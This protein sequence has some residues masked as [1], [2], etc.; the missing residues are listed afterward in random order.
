M[1]RIELTTRSLRT[2][3]VNLEEFPTPVHAPHTHPT[4]PLVLASSVAT[5]WLRET[6]HRSP[7]CRPSAISNCRDLARAW[8][9]QKEI[10]QN[11]GGRH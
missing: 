7:P 11:Q 5:K 1:V 6:P 3:C 8:S 4:S 2:A 10:L 9:A